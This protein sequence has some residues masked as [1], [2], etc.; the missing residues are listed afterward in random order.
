VS[1]EGQASKEDPK[2][3]AVERGE[4]RRMEEP[5]ILANPP[6]LIIDLT[7]EQPAVDSGEEDGGEEMMSELYRKAEVERY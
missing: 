5:F 4:S 7:V 1:P 6:A 2:E 3:K